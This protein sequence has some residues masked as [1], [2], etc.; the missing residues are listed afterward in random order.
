[1]PFEDGTLAVRDYGGHGPVVLLVHALGMCAMNWDRVA[2]PLARTCRVLAVDLPGH[3]QSTCTMRT[4]FSVYQCLIATA[5]H[6]D[7]T[8]ILVGHDHGSLCMTE[9][10]S[11][12]PDL[13]A[14][15]VAVGG[16]IVRTREEMR[17]IC[18]FAASDYFKEAM[19]TRFCLGATGVG[20]EA[21]DRVLDVVVLNGSIDWFMTDMEELRAEREY[22]LRWGDDGSWVHQPDP[23]DI[24][25]VGHFP[26]DHDFFPCMDLIP[27]YQVPVWMVHLSHGYDVQMA[28]REVAMAREHDALRLV[29]LESGQWPQYTVPGTLADLLAAIAAD[30]L[31]KGLSEADQTEDAESANGGVSA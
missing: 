19:R 2:I 12:R 24:A 30:P 7:V 9:A 18:D 29:Y 31:A 5:E 3:G 21:A 17:E 28:S 15:G 8:P 20:R 25:M 14:A 23:E 10:V 6:L 13:F 27:K 4:P 1:M 16:S 11:A 26:A 22:C